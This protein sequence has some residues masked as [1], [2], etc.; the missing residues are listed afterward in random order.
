MTSLRPLALGEIIDRSASAWREH[1]KPLFRLYL[2]FQLVQYVLLKLWQLA[3]Q[4]WFP[5]ALSSARMAEAIKTSPLSAA[6]Q[7]LVGMGTL[8]LTTLYFTQVAS[9]ALTGFVYPRLTGTGQPSLGDALRLGLRRLGPTSGAFAISVG[10]SV[11]VALLIQVPTAAL[12]GITAA[13]AAK[14]SAVGMAIFAGLTGLV[15]ALASLLTLQWFIVRFFCLSQVAAVEDIGAWRIFQRANELSSGRVE[16]GLLG[17]VKMRLTMLITVV[18]A[19]LGILFIVTSV[20]EA[21]V[22]VLYGNA[23][24]PTNADHSAVPATL[25]IPAELLQ[26]VAS[27]AF[28]PVY[29]VFQVLFYVDMRVRREGLDLELE[30]APKP[31]P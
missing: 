24:D 28:A 6:L 20:P 31:A 7:L 18:G 2:G 16:P 21:L 22:E 30:L 4:A 12:L 1:W 11:V 15:G 17:L 14:S 19:I 13:L 10:W 23:L 29:A 26:L 3:L 9:V 5:A 27:S 8:L 25:L